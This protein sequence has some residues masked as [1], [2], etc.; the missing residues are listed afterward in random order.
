MTHVCRHVPDVH[1]PRDKTYAGAYT[2]PVYILPIYTLHVHT[3]HVHTLH[4]HTL[5]LQHDIQVTALEI[6]DNA[7]MAMET[8]LCHS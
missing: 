3:L 1:S 5:H 4:L 8:T 2:C 6:I 7:K